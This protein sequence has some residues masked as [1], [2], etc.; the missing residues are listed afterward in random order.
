MT[1]LATTTHVVVV[2]SGEAAPDVVERGEDVL[3]RERAAL[4]RRCRNEQDRHLA[5]RRGCEV[6]RRAQPVARRR[7]ELLQPRLLDRRAPLVQETHGL[8]VDVDA[9]DVV[10]LAR[11]HGGERRAELPESDDGDP[12]QLRRLPP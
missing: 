1:V 8:R 11:E 9:E 2:A 5:V 4:V 7:D 12:H 3:V 10:A 6:G